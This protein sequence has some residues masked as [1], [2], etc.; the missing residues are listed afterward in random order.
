MHI[1]LWFMLLC[2]DH[3][4]FYVLIIMSISVMWHVL[5]CTVIDM[6]LGKCL[7]III[8]GIVIILQSKQVLL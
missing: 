1:C 3:V 5:L 7:I 6:H 2:F 4:K 8:S